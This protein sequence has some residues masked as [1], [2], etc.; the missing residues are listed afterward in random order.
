[1]RWYYDENGRLSYAADSSG[2]WVKLDYHP[3]LNL[4][5][6]LFN[7]VGRWIRLHYRYNGEISGVEVDE[8]RPA[9]EG[10]QQRGSARTYHYMLEYDPQGVPYRLIGANGETKL[11]DLRLVEKMLAGVASAPFVSVVLSLDL[12]LMEKMGRGLW[13]F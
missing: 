3:D 4:V 10:E 1:M 2:E 5:K 7:S 9:H 8:G 11:L 6:F 12:D 13:D